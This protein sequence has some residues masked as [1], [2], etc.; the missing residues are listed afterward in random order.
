MKKTL[1][2]HKSKTGMAQ[3]NIP[4]KLVKDQENHELWELSSVMALTEI[5]GVKEIVIGYYG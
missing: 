5:R 1:S 3:N 2:L 4:Q